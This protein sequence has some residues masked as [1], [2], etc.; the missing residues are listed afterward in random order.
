MNY[1]LDQGYIFYWGTSE[2][3]ADQVT[4]AHEIAQRLNMVGPLMDQPLYNMFN[5]TRVEMEYRPLYD[6][7]NYGLTVYS[8][9]MEGILAGRYLDSSDET[10]R[11][12][13]TG[14][15]RYLASAPENDIVYNIRKN[16]T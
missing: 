12:K 15:K 4:R 10:S 8:P 13:L 16:T 7:Y 1:L 6:K 3:S 9:L 5:R 14:Y 11:A 2:W